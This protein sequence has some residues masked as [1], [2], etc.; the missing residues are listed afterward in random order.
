MNDLR[1]SARQDV[2][3]LPCPF[4]GGVASVIYDGGNEVWNQSWRAGC[5]LCGVQFKESGSNS[6]STG[7]KENKAVDDAAKARAIT[8]WNRRSLPD[9]VPAEGAVA[10]QVSH[11]TARE[12]PNDWTPWSDCPKWEHDSIVQ[13]QP[14]YTR[15]RPLFAQAPAHAGWEKE[16]DEN[17]IGFRNGYIS[18]LEEIE[19]TASRLKKELDQ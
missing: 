6:W 4:C 16:P 15:T 17:R 8:A 11:M 7:N 2:A 10:W 9:S 14:K 1:A 13:N 5:T 3:L 18:A 19:Q 12:P